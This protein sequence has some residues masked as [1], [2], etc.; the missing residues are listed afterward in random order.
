M[1]KSEVK[2][3]EAEVKGIIPFYLGVKESDVGAA[4]FECLP[5]ETG[6][7]LQ[8]L[9]TDLE[10]EVGVIISDEDMKNIRPVGQ[11]ARHVK[12]KVA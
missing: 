7:H 9:L 4:S 3:I 12:S 8:E 6:I 5:L 11:L 10:T 1:P 2:D